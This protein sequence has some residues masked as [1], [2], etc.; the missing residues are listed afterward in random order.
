M[1]RI[2]PLMLAAAV[3][4]A[5]AFPASAREWRG[6]TAKIHVYTQWRS[7]IVWQFEGRG[8]CRSNVYGND[9]R[10]AARGAIGACLT[11]AW[12]RR[13][14]RRLPGSCF[15]VSNSNRPFVK[16]IGA[17]S[18]GTGP[19]AQGQQDF[20][21]AVERAACCTLGLTGRNESVSVGGSSSGDTGCARTNEAIDWPLES[22]YR[23]DCRSFRNS[24]FCG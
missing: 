7:A 24:G 6:C 1:N 5:L 22:N 17:T 12:D 14:E 21:W 8:S 18:F 20:K 23:V 15:P 16:G 4:A 19:G 3:L 10:R 11:E 9:C 13:W 2:I